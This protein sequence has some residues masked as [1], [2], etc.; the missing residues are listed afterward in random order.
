M[1]LTRPGLL[2]ALLAVLGKQWLLHYDSVGERRTIEER[3]LERQRKFEAIQR[4]KFDLV[5]QIFPLLLQFALLLFA[6]ALSLYLWT[7]HHVIAAMVLG[8][9][10][11]GSLFYTA[12][13]ISAVAWEDSPFQTSL[14]FVLKNL[15][16]RIPLLRRFGTRSRKVME[17][18]IGHLRSLWSQ[19][20]SA[21]AGLMKAMKPLLPLFHSAEASDPAPPPTHSPFRSPTTT[22]KGGFCCRMG[23]GNIH[24]SIHGAECRCDGTRIAVVARELRCSAFTEAAG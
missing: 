10:D 21:C 3:R 15:L 7:I 20:S 18:A 2:A 19:T 24:R 22:V 6:T 17:N 8:L 12:M 5:M 11:L 9:T 14:S 4:W 16:K 1:C 23:I 13:V